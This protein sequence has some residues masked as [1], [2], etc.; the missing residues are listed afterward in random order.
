MSFDDEVDALKK[1]FADNRLDPE[2]VIGATQE[3]EDK[4]AKKLK[5]DRLKFEYDFDD[6]EGPRVGVLYAKAPFHIGTCWVHG[7]GSVAFASESEYFP[8]LVAYETEEEFFK[9]AREFLKEG[10]AAF[11][12]D[13]EEDAYEA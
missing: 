12:L 7:D 8:P 5:S 6:D 10:L 3:L 1:K 13:E 9:E 4:L 11:E 2:Q